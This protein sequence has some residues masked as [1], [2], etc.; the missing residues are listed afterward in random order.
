MI[1]TSWAEA[2]GN[3]GSENRTKP[4]PP[5]FSSTPARITEPA[6]GACTWAS[7]SQV[8]TGHIGI[9]TAKLAKK[10]SQS[11][12]CASGGN[13]VVISTGIEVSP[14]AKFTIHSIA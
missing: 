10:A 6:V 12:V 4:Y 2:S 7:G 13:G 1:Q 8:W 5:I 3:I 9:L 14:P 11:Q